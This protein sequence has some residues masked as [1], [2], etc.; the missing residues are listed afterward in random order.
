MLLSPVPGVAHAAHAGGFLFG[1]AAAVLLA[2]PLGARPGWVVPVNAVVHVLVTASDVIHAWTIPSFGS[3]IDAMP[4]RI[5]ET[6]FKATEIG[7]YF[8]QCSELC[9][10]DHSYMPIVVEVVSIEDYDEWVLKQQADS[11]DRVRRARRRRPF[12]HGT[13]QCANVHWI[14]RCHRQTTMHCHAWLFCRT[15]ETSYRMLDTYWNHA[16][17]VKRARKQRRME[18]M[19]DLSYFHRDVIPRAEWGLYSRNPAVTLTFLRRV[20]KVQCWDTPINVSAGKWHLSNYQ[21]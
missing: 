12:V 18:A 15:N 16:L 1:G 17:K 6:W 13:L 2:P 4:G 20:F 10:K 14:E 21:G 5:N 7:T 19:M 9:G 11:G 8:G 3:K